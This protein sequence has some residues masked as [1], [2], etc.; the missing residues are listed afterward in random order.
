[1]HFY[2]SEQVVEDVADLPDLLADFDASEVDFERL[3]IEVDEDG[4]RFEAEVNVPSFADAAQGLPIGGFAEDAIS[5]N[6][7]LRMPGTPDPDQTN[8]DFIDADGTMRWELPL[9]GGTFNVVAVTT[10]ES[11][12]IPPWAILAGGLAIIGL[13]AVLFVRLRSGT[14]QAQDALAQ[15]EAPPAPE[16]INPISD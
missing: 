8:A 1:M 15:V 6:L 13:L 14:S 3:V 10:S 4:G 2:I 11:S 12:G 9:D 5:S 7:L 16:A